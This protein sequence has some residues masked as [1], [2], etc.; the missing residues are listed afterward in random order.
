MVFKPFE[1]AETTKGVSY[2]PGTGLGLWASET[3]AKLHH[4]EAQIQFTSITNGADESEATTIFT[5]RMPINPTQRSL[6]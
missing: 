2:M 6:E 3:I 1:R 4:D 5:F